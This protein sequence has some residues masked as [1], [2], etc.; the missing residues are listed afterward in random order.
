MTIKSL[1]NIIFEEVQA[2]DQM[3]S[4]DMLMSELEIDEINDN[5][6]DE[7]FE[8]IENEL[9]S[10][11]GRLRHTKRILEHTDFKQLYWNPRSTSTIRMGFANEVDAAKNIIPSLL[12]YFIDGIP[13]LDYFLDISGGLYD[14][15]RENPDNTNLTAG[16]GFL[17][18]LKANINNGKYQ[19]LR[20]EILGDTYYYPSIAARATL[21]ETHNLWIGA[22]EKIINN[23]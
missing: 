6:S 14:Q 7:K 17:S 19:I 10:E 2:V 15:S 5:S 9:K 8:N 1:T 20:T 16:L 3:L 23:Q 22:F 21:E 18:G 13:F 12:K 4:D 11:I